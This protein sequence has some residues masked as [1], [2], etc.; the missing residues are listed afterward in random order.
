MVCTSD[1]NQQ[2]NVKFNAK[3][4]KNISLALKDEGYDM[5]KLMLEVI[6]KL[7]VKLSI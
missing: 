6:N 7:L 4:F 1:C 5:K 2:D 3:K